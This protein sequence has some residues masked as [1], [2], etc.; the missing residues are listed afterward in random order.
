MDHGSPLRI[1]GKRKQG[2]WYKMLLS[3]MVLLQEQLLVLRNLPHIPKDSE[4]ELV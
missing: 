2:I 1:T 3:L 4:R